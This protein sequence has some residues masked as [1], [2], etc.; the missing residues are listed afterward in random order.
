MCG[1]GRTLSHIRSD[2]SV[3][4]VAI[5]LSDEIL[6]TVDRSTAHLMLIHTFYRLKDR[7]TVIKIHVRM[8]CRSD[9]TVDVY[10]SLSPMHPTTSTNATAS[11]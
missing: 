3:L 8:H 5:K 10:P 9:Y 6:N 4:K 2:N 1:T 11:I 7:Q